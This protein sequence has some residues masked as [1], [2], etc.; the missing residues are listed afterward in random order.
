MSPPCLT[1]ILGHSSIDQLTRQ[2]GN[3]FFDRQCCERHS[4][5]FYT[6]RG[7]CP[8]ARGCGEWPRSPVGDSSSRPP[9][10]TCPVQPLYSPIISAILYVRRTTRVYRI[11]IPIWTNLSDAHLV[12]GYHVQPD[13]WSSEPSAWNAFHHVLFGSLLGTSR[14][15]RPFV[16]LLPSRTLR[17]WLTRPPYN[18]STS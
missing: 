10:A 2:S 4:C 15:A 17:V 11:F 8:S 5:T 14:K 6:K 13:Y 9:V 16:L 18:S 3:H 1:F 12:L 7:T